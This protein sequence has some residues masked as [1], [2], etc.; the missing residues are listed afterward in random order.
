MPTA[1]NETL[2]RIKSYENAGANGIFVT[3]ISNKNDIKEGV[4]GT[5]LPV[6]VLAGLKN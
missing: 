5:S 4:D 3:Y 1:L 6:N 2:I